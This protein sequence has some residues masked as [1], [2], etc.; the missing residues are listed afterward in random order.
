MKI[1][2]IGD[3]YSTSGREMVSKY[4]PKMREKYNINFIIANGENIAHGNGITERYYHFLLD[5]NVNVV[6]MGNHTYGNADIF[7]FIDD[8]KSLVRP[9][10][11]PPS[12]KGVGYVTIKYNQTTI[13]VFQVIG[14]TFI[15]QSADCPFRATEELLKEVKSDIYICDFHGEA[16]SEKIAYGYHFDGKVKIIFGTHTH[17]QTN[18]ARVLNNGSMYIT[19]VGMTGAL[20]GVIGVEPSSIIKKFITGMPVK[21]NPMETGLKQF[22]AII[23]DINEKTHKI[24]SYDT[25]HIVE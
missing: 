4:V 14:R 18:D 8:A 11:Y 21:H 9:L 19:D 12:N 6:T 10:N 22:S 25:I 7:H 17:V 3:I 1:L 15:N 13:T 20:D 2:I 24:T 23:V 16:T 5:N